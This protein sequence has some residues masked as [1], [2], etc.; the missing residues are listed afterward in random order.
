MT[1]LSRLLVRPK[2]ASVLDILPKFLMGYETQ[3]GA[4]VTPDSAMRVAA[5]YSCVKVR[6]E[7]VGQT[8]LLVYERLA[9]NGKRRATEHWLYRL[10][11]ETPNP[12]QTP[13]EFRELIEAHV[14][15]RG[16][17]Y[18]LAPRSGDEVTELLP[19]PPWRVEPR[20]DGRWGILYRVTLP[21]GVP[22]DVPPSRILHIPGFGF[23]GKWGLSPI[24]YQ[25]ETVGLAQ[26]LVEHGAR[27]FKHGAA[28]GG[29]IH[30]GGPSIPPLSAEAYDRMQESFDEKYAGVGNAHKTI[31][32]EEGAKY[33]KIGMTD[34]DA[35]Y[36]E[37]RAFSRSEIA[38][39]FRIPPH[40]IG[41]LA[42][43]TFSN[44]EHQ[45]LEL[46]KFSLMPS[47]T[48]IEQRVA[49]TLLSPADRRRFFAE[50]L[51]DGLLRGDQ[52]SRHDAYGIAIKDGWMTRNEA[53]RFENMDPGPPALDEFLTPM[54]LA[55][56]G[57]T[58][59][60]AP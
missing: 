18:A 46:V 42:R 16:N 20:E 24:A 40:M 43:A 14:A 25:R 53:R 11:H 30:H 38:G 26:Q 2:N 56:A 31:I 58:D 27:L 6:A 12:W 3:G 17:F 36:L 19:L 54:N 22:F 55:P 52:K 29:I 41:D 47:F 32:L 28:I 5:V 39:M 44:I 35:Q 33:E 57:A 49:H 15:L 60:D 21:D 48:R 45:S 23:N 1:L 59:D 50:F 34:K 13:Y 8:P 51:V 9:D 4:M 10:L 7:L 37:A